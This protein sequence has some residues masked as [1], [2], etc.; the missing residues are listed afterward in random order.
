MMSSMAFHHIKDTRSLL[1]QL[2]NVT[3]SGG[4]L[5]VADLDSDKGQFH[6]DLRFF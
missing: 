4:M 3:A 6:G 1:E 2:Y 5:C